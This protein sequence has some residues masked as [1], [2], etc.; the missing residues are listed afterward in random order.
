MKNLYFI[1]FFFFFSFFVTAQTSSEVGITEGQLAVSLSGAATYTIPIAVPSGING[2]VPQISLV[3]NSQGGNGVAGY[4]WNIS[5]VSVIT[6][7]PSTRYHDGVIDAVNFNAL[8]RFALDG[9]RLIVKNGTVYETENF[10]NVKITSYGVHPGGPNYGPAY[11]VVEYPDGSKAYYGNSGDSRSI[12][13]WAITYWENPQGVRISYT[14]S[15]TNNILDIV[16]IKYG[17]T[18]STAP[19]NEIKFNYVTRKRV[20][21]SYIGGLSAIRST[22]LKGINIIGNGAGFRN[23]VL[24]YEETSLK[25]E[26]LDNIT[27]KSGD[28]AKSYNP[29]KFSYDTTVSDVPLKVG[30]SATLGV[31]GINYVNSDYITGDFDN[32][33]KTDI[34]LFSKTTSLKNK[35][36]LY[37]NIK[38]ESIGLINLGATDLIG[39]FE[40][41]FPASFLNSANKLLPQGWAVLKKTDTKCILSLHAT[42]P[43]SPTFKHY[44]KEYNFSKTV[45]IASNW[46]YCNP[47]DYT[48]LIL[49]NIPMEY[50]SG[51]F[52][53]DGLTDVVAI[54]KSFYYTMRVCNFST[55][56][57]EYKQ[58]RH[59]GGATHF[60][61]LDRG[62]SAN[63]PENIGNIA[64]ND[65][66][67]SKFF[68]ADFDGDG[69]SD[70]Y[71]FE[72][73]FIR[74][75][76]LNKEN[77]LVLLYQ[78]ISADPGIALDR[79]ILLGDFNGDGKVDFVIPNAVGQDSWNFYLAT[80]IGFNKTNAAIGVAYKAYEHGAYGVVGWSSLTYS[81]NDMSFVANDYNGDGKTD[82]LF[83]QNLTVDYIWVNNNPNY[84]Q[85]GASQITKLV[86][87]EN[88]SVINGAISFSMINT[89]S[90]VAGIKRYP[91]PIFFNQNTVNQNLEYSLIS[92]N[93]T[94]TFNSPKDNRTDVLLKGIT[95]GNG[96]KE[97]IT[98][99]PLQQDPYEPVYTP[100]ALIE[101]F[102]N[103]DIAVVPGF[104]I[105]S[106]LEKQ[107]KEVYKKQLYFYSGA[108]SNTE[109][110]GFLGFRSTSKTNWYDND[111][112]G[113]ISS[114][115]KNDISLRG[116]NVENYTVLGLHVPLIPD[117]NAKSISATIVKEK[118][119]T[120]SATENLVATQSITLKPDSW[121]KSGSA[122]SAKINEEANIGTS[123]NTPSNFITKSL[124]FYESE[125]M[126]NKVFKIRNRKTKQFNN[127]DYTS[128]ETTVEYDADYN[129]L[130][131]V[132]LLKESG[133]TV[134]TTVSTVSYD[135]PS[136]SPY[137]V[138]RPKSKNQSITISGDV[139]TSEELY[140]YQ[141]SL[142]TQIKKK[143]TN[144]DYIV[145]DNSYD[146]F[147]NI[148]Q[149][150]IT[151]S[152]LP[153]RVTSYGYD[154]SGRFLTR[155][156]DI[157]GLS[158][159]F[160]YNID[161]TLKSET[162]PY[163]LTTSY[164][165]DSWLKK[166][167]TT[168]YLGK[169][170]NYSYTRS[171][172]KTI[173]TSTADDG[174]V[175]E[176]VFDDL[177]RKIKTGSKN[178]MGT[179]TYVDYLYDIQD[180]NYKVSEPYFGTTGT[181]WN[182]TKYDVYGRVTQNIVATGKT[183]DI[184]YSG[185]T[186][187]LSNGTKSKTSVKNAIG[188]VVS[189]TDTPGG[190]IRYIY[191][192]NGNL[193]E[194]DYGSVK[195]SISQDG[196]GR[197][198]SLS[199]PSV[200]TYTYAYNEFGEIVR[201]TTPNGETNY[202]LDAVGKLTQ[203]NVSGT[204]TSS[205]TTYYYGT[206]S[207]L[208]TGINL[209]D[210]KNPENNRWQFIS[211]DD[212]KRINKTEEKINTTGVSFEK[213]FNYDSFG[214][215]LTESSR[216]EMAGKTSIK[217]VMNTYKYGSH[218]QIL[219][220]N[221]NTVLWQTNT[222]SER[223]QVTD[224]QSGAV[225]IKNSYDD[226][227]FPS[228][229]DYKKPSG[230]P[231]S[232][233]SLS[234]SF[235]P[236]RGNLM[237]KSNK[238]FPRNDWFEYDALDR[239]TSFTNE[240][241]A[242]EEQRYDDKGRIARNS[243]G[244][245]TY[246]NDR[247]YQNSSI[248]LSNEAQSYYTA[249]PTQSITYN[250]FKSPVQIVEPG[251]DKINF[252]YNDNNSRSVMYYGG[253]QDDKMLRPLRKYYS[254][255]GTM[256]IKQNITTG[257]IEFL[258]Y[259]GGDGYT[260]PVALK[261]DGTTQSYLYLLRDYQGTIMTIAD[262]NA[263][264]LE[265]RIF[266]AWGNI[267]KVEDGAGNALS[268]L[269]ILDR[270]YTGHEHLQSVGLINMN[271]R[272]YDPKLHRFLQ[273]DNFVQDPF[274]TQN[275][276]RY[277][278]CWNN[279]AKYTDP[280]GEWFWTAF[281]VGAI[282]G[283]VSGGVSYAAQAIQTGNWNWGQFGLSTL[284]GAL[285][286]GVSGGYASTACTVTTNAVVNAFA[287]G[288]IAGMMPVYGVQMG[289][290]SF[291]LSPAIAFGN[292]MG[293]G[294]SISATYSSGDFSFSAG[295]GIMSNS[296]YN[297]FGKDGLEIRKSIL[298]A[299]D[300]GKTGFSLGTNFWSGNG[301]MQ[302]FK[303][304]TGLLG[305]HFGDFRAMYENDGKPFSGLSGDG[306]DQYRTAA[307][308]LNVGKFSA[309]FNLFTGK[310]DDQSYNNEKSGN[311]DGSK[312]EIGPSR[313]GRYGEYYKNGLVDERGPKYRMGAAYLGYK[314]YRVGV[315][316]EWIRHAIQ[317]V[318][319][320]GT[321]IAN[322][323]MFEMQSGD[324]NGYMQYK[325]S[326]IFTTW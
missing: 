254:A 53:G 269:T 61:N 151:A 216:A 1:L 306:N 263:N 324:W 249:R 288:F 276:N 110:L 37:L 185:L 259:I 74:V 115:S 68:V 166:T 227:G 195:T 170:N 148:I 309:G 238:Y 187:T 194:T 19:I 289:D 215:I 163:G 164:L 82:I 47:N 76:T 310:R 209:V 133:S 256:E 126:P 73:N 20:E 30:S 317:N 160:V 155:S 318:A 319:I 172:S 108:V 292:T 196:W 162:N 271:G 101:T 267:V 22:I 35:Y 16:S 99:K 157:E 251:K 219:D 60:F 286:G 248:M 277:G 92:D 131:S 141:N 121:I 5:G 250:A 257:A 48:G 266:D 323:R 143:G 253:M 100:T 326:N 147:G 188:N 303:Q 184:T 12:T 15:S 180:R 291:S 258:A 154:P 200:G 260:A 242:K 204:D 135:P 129:P 218:W 275:Y 114:L 182:E 232:F 246:C 118:D 173:I 287:S 313:S 262:A 307:L 234:F 38:S 294:A 25:Y 112:S 290:W 169:N 64:I 63:E 186:T 88:Q 124:S 45:T 85:N 217:T 91:V 59:P 177:G 44:E 282:I 283:A 297:G 83:Q 43:S 140:F 106:M 46:S 95:N 301:G 214:R 322:Q 235:D 13:D 84:S 167:T 80:G 36:T 71:V 158:T 146:I 27:E 272:I 105:V 89:T 223:G 252:S 237:A 31:S 284:G 122:F 183:T 152:G 279:P 247:P 72:P 299:Y 26:R 295:V 86:L 32:N 278:Y 56:I 229:F 57:T 320:H 34:I 230:Y 178:I 142:L 207:K 81:H 293:I 221:N 168:D 274:N 120:I 228:Y 52:N 39:N 90:Q 240:Q 137:V 273:P 62:L 97:T 65:S 24:G 6:R 302:E 265:K 264:V 190:T 241:G 314:T 189:V 179:F 49:E 144:T 233:L 51:D 298:A 192:A 261:S 119:Y 161:G 171:G 193:K 125:L 70:I 69:K 243:L 296:N 226:L 312:G 107:S 18:A 165:Y 213:S 128:S 181:H 270:G 42:E 28:N 239:L 139:M 281:A 55:Q 225:T 236:Q 136:S 205:K 134:Q 66:S 29:T 201:E 244:D 280:S 245:Y 198:T 203:K 109:G 199:D 77:K 132:T 117:P 176:E 153:A 7:I 93:A 149:K 208:L 316:S 175:S 210:T 116:A 3:Y 220:V 300:D 103:I 325:T 212:Y 33:G 50:L 113:I 202:V 40:T 206:D 79:Q 41:I 111:E 21:Q 98:Y 102:P 150:T 2:V 174:S 231:S 104:K 17:G 145:E 138:G 321:F 130:K 311:W 127:L 96:V 224:A 304:K 75:Y 11:F 8:D 123:L 23:Y 268:G 211:Y 58:T 197:K 54:E 67:N 9:Q 191:F 222:V 14:Y 315:N 308:S 159:S 78:T 87:L 285:I 94:V 305:L 4:G 255:D 156:T 10:S